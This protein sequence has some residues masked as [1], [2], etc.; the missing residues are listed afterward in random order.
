MPV[1]DPPAG[2]VT[3]TATDAAAPTAPPRPRRTQ[4]ERR[5]STRAALLA[6]T[7]AALL[8]DGHA[9]VTTSAIARRAG[10]SQGALYKHFATKQELLAAAAEHLY[11][12]MIARFLDR[13]G[14][15]VGHDDVPGATVDLL[16]EMFNRPEMAVAMELTV[17]ARTDPELR[18]RLEPVVARH[19]ARMRGVAADLF[20]EVA[21]TAEYEALLDLTLEAMLGM[22][23]SRVVD[24]EPDHYQRVLSRLTDLAREALARDPG[25]TP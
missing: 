15:L 24:R 20:P 12:V 10:V 6:A 5:R 2:G 14:H 11:D 7:T 17:A 1:T 18:A 21:G 25:G 16:W 9:D 22:A 13:F 4:A 19:A 8:D 3:T 23:M